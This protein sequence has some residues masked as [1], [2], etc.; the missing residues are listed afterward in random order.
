MHTV[1]I[2]AR[3]EAATVGEVVGRIKRGHPELEVLVVDNGSEDHTAVVAKEAGARVV[4]EPTIGFGFA[5]HRGFSECKT[6]YVIKT[7]A[8]I[9]N[10]SSDWV[11][12]LI[13][14]NKS[15]ADLA[16]ATFES[17]YDEFPV[18]NLALRPLAKHLLPH[19]VDIETPLSGTYSVRV[20]CLN[21]P[22]LPKTWAFDLA[23]LHQ[24]LVAPGKVI[25]VPIGVLSDAKRSIRYYRS[26]AQDI[27]DF[28]MQ[29]QVRQSE[30]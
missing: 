1:V 9:N 20:G 14:A 11:T 23:V 29:L 13:S 25:E 2:P 3:N 18:T 15:G 19:V 26:M 7:D 4:Q 12:A 28:M 16:R 10:F 27:V 17:D 30:G 5:L 24:V 6:E 8:D 22:Q 21:F